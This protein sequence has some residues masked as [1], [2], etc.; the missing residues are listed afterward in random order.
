MP[1]LRRTIAVA[2]ALALVTVSGCGSA[3]RETARAA[4]RTPSTG[5]SPLSSAPQLP[6]T[7]PASAQ[8]ACGSA[9]ARH[10]WVQAISVDG[11]ERWRTALRVGSQGVGES[12]APLLAAGNVIAAQDGMV[13]ALGE[14]DGGVRWVWQ[15]GKS[16]YGMW[17]S[18]PTVVVLTDQVG[19]NASF[20]ALR[21][22]DGH[23]VWRRAIPPTGIL[24]DVVAT[25]S[26]GLAWVRADG[27]VQEMGMS[28]GTIRWSHPGTRSPALI[29]VDGRVL[30]AASGTVWAYDEATG[31]LD[32]TAGGMPPIPALTAVAGRVLVSSGTFGGASPT[33]ITALDPA[34]GTV[35]WRFD[36]GAS[37]FIL[38]GDQQG[39][40]LASVPVSSGLVQIDPRN[41]MLLW[42]AAASLQSIDTLP[43]LSSGL[44]V[45][46]EGGVASGS[47]TQLVAR[48]VQTG[49]VVW[50]APVPGMLGGSRP[51]LAVGSLVV[52]ELP[53]QGHGTASVLR[54]YQLGSGHVQWSV[55]VPTYTQAPASHDA[56]TIV[57][58]S[59]D[60]GYAC[61]AT[62]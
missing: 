15:G 50:S 29:D 33:A 9:P 12:L 43:L 58:Q 19:S 38:D 18:G 32:W 30:F 48:L 45:A 17:L 56:N 46:P 10:A 16:V 28:D 22:S 39:I 26:D 23:Q 5:A 20:T 8:G 57:V 54:A 6:R 2:G 44:I 25:S 27:A 24:G 11:T 60:P 49:G 61:G 55:P 53:T 36:N 7:P 14:S 40:L 37:P 41:G 1:Q 3:S 47:K 51:L 34:T 31:R 4:V 62:G 42:R 59:A 35:G 21:L 52:A 13:T